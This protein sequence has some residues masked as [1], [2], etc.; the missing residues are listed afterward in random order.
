LTSSAWIN[1]NSD[2]IWIE[3]VAPKSSESDTGILKKH[4]AGAIME[5][6]VEVDDIDAFY[7]QMQAKGIL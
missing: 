3:L 5:L 2:S 4:G 1:G 6:C 7:D